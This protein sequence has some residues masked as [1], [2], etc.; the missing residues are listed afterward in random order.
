V[1]VSFAFY[2][3]VTNAVRDANAIINKALGL[4]EHRGS[5][6]LAVVGGGPSIRHHVEELRNWA[7]D[8]WAV[9]GTINWCMSHGIDAAFYTVDAAKLGRWLF[10]MDR[11]KRA[12]IAIDCDPDMFAALKG[13]EVSTLPVPDGGP[14]SANSADWF[15]VQTGYS[16]LTYFG[17]ESSFEETTHAYSEAAEIGQWI[18]VRVGGNNY[19]T[20]PE[21][22][23]QARIMS[24]V[25]RAVP[26]YYDERSGGLLSAMVEHGMEYELVEV[27]P[28]LERALMT[29]A[30]AK[31]M[32]A[33]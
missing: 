7:G 25:I 30:E 16:G 14:T 19:R 3:S 8:I 1:T 2:P 11:I 6:R 13:A 28:E 17:C 32:G 12:I 20:K 4:P 29:R 18:V 9:N 33:A 21:F 26:S 10:P 22:L 15:A 24:E 31:M 27:S 23:E 5:G